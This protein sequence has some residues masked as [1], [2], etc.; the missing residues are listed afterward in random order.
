MIEQRY[1][2]SEMI[3]EDKHRKRGAMLARN[4]SEIAKEVGSNRKEMAYH[5]PGKDHARPETTEQ[6]E[7]MVTSWCF[8]ILC[9]TL[10]VLQ[11]PP[12]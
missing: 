12:Y 7:G 11:Y 6:E 10:L 1:N 9:L 5:Q 4:E 3:A 2:I 8:G